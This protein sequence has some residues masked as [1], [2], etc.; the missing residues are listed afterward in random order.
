MAGTLEVAPAAS[1]DGPVGPHRGRGLLAGADGRWVALL[2]ALPVLVFAVPALVG[3]PVLLGDDLSQ[4]EPLRALVGADLRHGLLP[5]LDPYLWSGAPLL[6]GW[7]A[8]A[9][10]PLTWLFAVLPATG[11]WT[12]GLVV[13]W[14]VA[15]LSLYA[16]LRRFG[17]AT[18]ACGVGALSFAFGGAFLA[19]V[20][21]FGLVAGMSWVPLQLLAVH[22]LTGPAGRGSRARWTAAL[23]ATFALTVLAGEPRAIDDAFAV[24]VC[25]A[26]WR[27]ARLEGRRLAAL[28]PILA[29]IGLG[30]G[31]GA[32][33][34][35]P[36]L[37]AVGISQRAATSFAFFSSGSLP[38]R[39]LALLVVPDL[40]GGSGSF[41][42]PAFL[43]SYNLT[44]VTGYV[45]VLP[46]IGAVALLGR[47]RARRRLP[48]W[49]V[50][51]LVALAG[52]VL[53]LGGNTPLGRL[54]ARLP[55]YGAQRLQSRNLVVVDLALAVLLAYFADGWLRPGA[56]VATDPSPARRERRF[57]L[58][59]GALVATPALAFLVRG[60]GFLEA[61]GV[62]ARA[63]TRSGALS[64]YVVPFLVLV[65][66]AVVGLGRGRS[67]PDRVR[68]RLLVG[69]VLADLVLFALLAV[70]AVGASPAAPATPRLAASRATPA[71]GRGVG[72]GGRRAGASPPAP[73]TAARPLASLHLAGRFAVY[74]PGLV[75]PGQLTTLGAPDRN[76]A[77][78][79]PSV[80][81]YGSIVGGAYATGTGAHG[82]T[83]EGQDVFAPRAAADG[84]FDELDTTTLVTLPAYLL[85]A[86]G[87]GGP[88]PGAATGRRQVR[89]GHGATW[90]F[91]EPLAV[92]SVAV[93]V[94]GGRLSAH[95]RIGVV[96]AGGGTRW[97]PA[98]AVPGRVVEPA[99]G[100]TLVASWR[101]P[102]TGVGLRLAAVGGPVAV[103]APRLVTA[104]G[105]A[106]VADGQLAGAVVP[107]RWRYG[108]SDGAFA[109]FRD[110]LARP[111][112]RL[113][114]LPGRRLV[115]AVLRSPTGP[116]AFPASVVVSSPHG[117]VVVR[118][119]SDIPGWN[120]HWL[121][122]A[123]G[124]E[125]ALPVRPAGLV[126]AVRVPAGTGR[127]DWTYEAPGLLPGAAASLA[128]LA[129]LL[130]LAAVGARHAADARGRSGR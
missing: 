59:A 49:F 60:A 72:V 54:L 106:F 2:V 7:N 123:G 46:A 89:P 118:A 43:A 55:A 99:G 8:G 68:A 88:A 37:D 1:L 6:G 110:V 85:T 126:Q 120:A 63:A 116:P 28:V 16:L 41:G 73:G 75:E 38:D 14:W 48:E 52:V 10:Y 95:A 87:G 92:G 25:F 80:L 82:L 21:H 33:Q 18:A 91:G 58:L 26:A 40:L 81:G 51:H 57:E 86:A 100:G 83:G 11:A 107:P 94:A 12:M 109:L 56:E 115:G 74:D 104:S 129:A 15:G 36:G 79:T 127:L 122:F 32:I 93:P 69:F 22:H 128:C 42:Q 125:V 17:L 62:P 47:L 117:A 5:V 35:L 13:T 27:V 61:L 105:A 97:V 4:N 64:P 124:P 30:I 44:E 24:V 65:V 20:V 70:V 31:V 45:G 96:T 77:T 84:V 66:G 23:G 108:G 71:T 111:P 3:H 114:P 121:P 34:W 101:R 102:V 29:G 76:V 98:R 67:L 112:L 50:W 103:G 90:Y 19:Q 53:A 39:W 119:V 113:E 130:A 78:G 9:A